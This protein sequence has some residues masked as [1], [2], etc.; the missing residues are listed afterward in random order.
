MSSMIV[1]CVLVLPII[2]IRASEQCSK[3]HYEEKLLEKMIRLEIS[4]EA[5]KK[6]IDKSR[7]QVT[8][9]LENLQNERNIIE[10]TLRVKSDK[11][12]KNLAVAVQD[13]TA[14]VEEKMEAE[15]EKWQSKLKGLF[16]LYRVYFSLIKLKNTLSYPFQKPNST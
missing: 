11:I 14:K 4:V 5:M 8:T 3:Y 10:E 6:D 15:R 13:T 7:H 2:C 16:S 1:I 12:S 9:A